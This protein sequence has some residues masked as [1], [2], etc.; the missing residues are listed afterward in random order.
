MPADGS[1]PL[2]DGH[3]RAQERVSKP[4]LSWLRA[5]A[6]ASSARAG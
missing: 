4:A 3:E 5:V 1:G 2:M 6:L